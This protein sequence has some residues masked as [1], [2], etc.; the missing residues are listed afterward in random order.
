[1]QSTDYETPPATFSTCGTYRYHLARQ[2]GPGNR[3]VAAI[4][5]NP[6]EAAGELN[7][8]TIRRWIRAAKSAGFD[9]LS[10]VNLFAYR[11]TDWRKLRHLN[12]DIRI[13]PENDA[14]IRRVTS[15]CAAVMVAWGCHGDR[16]KQRAQLVVRL[17]QRPLL[18]LGTTRSGQPRHPMVVPASQQLVPW[19][20]PWNIRG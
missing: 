19:E 5:L 16:W 9:A 18:C 2:W 4:G 17:I 11:A 6:G 15:D 13:G 7:G 12:D 10:V 1:M 3:T 14:W 20:P 8:P